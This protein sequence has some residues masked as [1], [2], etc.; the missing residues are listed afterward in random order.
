MPSATTSLI[1]PHRIAPRVISACLLVLATFAG[2]TGCTNTQKPKPV[3]PRYPTLP[4]KP[5]PAFMKETVFERV[6]LD[7]TQ[8]LPV[9]NFGLVVNLVDGTGDA[10]NAPLA[11]REYVMKQMERHGQGAARGWTDEA[12]LRPAEMLRDP[13]VAIVRHHVHPGHPA[14]LRDGGRIAWS[15]G[16]VV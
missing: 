3:P 8:P 11:V 2:A 4:P 13:R 9:S 6:D 14:P 16:S 10:Q 15:P 12:R 7:N 5:V 1:P